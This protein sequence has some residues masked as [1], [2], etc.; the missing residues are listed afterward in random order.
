MLPIKI[1]HRKSTTCFSLLSGVGCQNNKQN[2]PKVN[3]VTTVWDVED[4][5][6]ANFSVFWKYS[7]HSLPFGWY[8]H[9]TKKNTYFG[10]RGQII[11]VNLN[12][13]PVWFCLFFSPD[14]GDAVWQTRPGTWADCC[15]RKFAPCILIH[16]CR[17]FHEELQPPFA[18]RLLR[19]QW[20]C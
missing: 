8:R 6:V 1:L 19:R 13:Q 18:G 12:L 11:K 9:H 4:V 17:W 5:K 3:K 2:Q 14:P 15:V 10:V 20:I 16:P 7:E